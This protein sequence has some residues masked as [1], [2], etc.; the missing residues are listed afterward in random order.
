MRRTRSGTAWTGDRRRG[1][2]GRRQCALRPDHLLVSSGE[3]DRDGRRRRRQRQR[4]RADPA[5]QTGAQ[6]R[7]HPRAA[8]IRARDAGF[9]ATGA[10]NPWYYELEAPGFNWRVSDI[11]CALGLSQLAKLQRFV[12]A[13][14]VLVAC[15]DELLAPLAPL[16][17]PLEARSAFAH[18]L[19][20]L[21]GADRFRRG[22]RSSARR[23]M[24]AHGG[25]RHRHAGAL[26]SACTGSPT[27][28][29]RYGTTVLPG[30]E[31][32]YASTLTL[33]AAC[34]HE[35]S[36]CCARRRGAEETILKSGKK[37][38]APSGVMKTRAPSR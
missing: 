19:A 29:T 30:A 24:R 11:N 7:H 34:R 5:P 16:V 20:H 26:H 4:S 13:R 38:P 22:R 6:S 28:R 37:P 10:V 17:R 27:T 3:D 1:S 14:R 32:Y 12:D 8:R 9:D 23:L 21:Y 35:R 33:A 18:R 15:Y 2:A 25:R 31:T 36:R